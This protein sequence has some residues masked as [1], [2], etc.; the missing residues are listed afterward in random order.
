MVLKLVSDT[1]AKLE[2]MKGSKEAG[3]AAT[4]LSATG[5]ILKVGD[6]FDIYNLIAA[7]GSF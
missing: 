6:E 7:H 4:A 5:G 2:S 1:L 3:T